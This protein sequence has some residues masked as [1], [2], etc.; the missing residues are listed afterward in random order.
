[1]IVEKIIVN[2]HRLKLKNMKKLLLFTFALIVLFFSTSSGQSIPNASFEEWEDFTT[3]MVPTNWDNPNPET[4]LVNKFTVFREEGVVYDGAYSAKLQ[5]TWVLVKLVPGLLTLGEFTVNYATMTY[6]IEGGV[7][8]NQRPDYLSGIYQF[9]PVYSDV[10]SVAVYFT[11][12]NTST[13]QPD[14]IGTGSFTNSVTT[15]EWTQFIAPINFYTSDY[16]DT[17][18]IVILSSLPDF[19]NEGTLLYIDKLAF[20]VGV[21]FPQ[22]EPDDQVTF[23][24]NRDQSLLEVGFK[25][26]QT[27]PVT[28]TLYNL[29]GQPVKSVKVTTDGRALHTIHL[30]GL[31]RGL[32]V[33][34][35]IIGTSRLIRKIII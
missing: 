2:S 24:H 16:P 23:L 33:T 8:F 32:Y 7:P 34:E 3:Y 20:D 17:M 28:I 9:I 19:G 14:T 31:K 10:M 18:N 27:D 29:L 15:T 5:T 35:I 26:E 1:M 11:L 30:E 22:K 6:Y 12:F 13:N 21:G 25:T 4:S